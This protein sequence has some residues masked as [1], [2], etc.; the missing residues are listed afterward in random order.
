M[1]F[2]YIIIGGGLCGLTAGISLLESG[3]KVCIVSSGQSALHFCGGSFGLLGKKGKLII[4]KP[5]ENLE[6][7]PEGH[8]YRHIGAENIARL[9]ESVPEL[10]GKAGVSVSGN[11]SKN[12]FTLTPFGHLRPSWLTLEGFPVIKE[13]TGKPFDKVLIVSIKGFL[14][15]YPAFMA[16][17]LGKMGV[18]C[19]IENIEIDRITHLRE[20]S[21]DMRAV[22]LAK[23]MDS[24]SIEELAAKINVA[25]KEGETV[26]VP[27]ILGIKSEKS[28]RRL[29]ELV[30]N[31]LYCVP[32][33]PVSVP[34]VRTQNSLKKY[35][36][37]L[38]GTY[39]LG[40]HVDQGWIENGKV[41]ELR[42]ANLG[43]DHLKADVYVLATGS[44]FSEG[45]IATPTGFT[46]PVFGLD[47]NAPAKRS[48]WYSPDFFDPQ[49]YMSYGVETDKEFHPR[50]DGKPIANLYAAGA[51]LAHCD[52]LHEDS[53]AGTAIICGLYVAENILKHN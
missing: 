40:D 14:E 33:I 52:A 9:A 41:T 3:K 36:E 45:I 23:Q 27:A 53:G 29:S 38:G 42:T 7:L 24:S 11:A 30:N 48:E 37:S 46:E 16:D 35:F 22:S 34:G 39:L 19:R 18:D 49:P 50:K 25:A 28:F 10:L 44:I 5:I 2:D 1:K 13:A 20:S 21:F 47:V 43:E 15:S 4:E 31:T 32:T 26:L 8:P 12:H 17:N 6:N 51:A